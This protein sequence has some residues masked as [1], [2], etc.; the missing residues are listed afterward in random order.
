MRLAKAAGT[1][2]LVVAG[3]VTAVALASLIV[4]PLDQRV[5]NARRAEFR[6]DELD[7]FWPTDLGGHAECLSYVGLGPHA[8]D[9]ARLTHLQRDRTAAELRSQTD[10]AATAR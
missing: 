3:F 1:R 10:S 5:V 6:R 8:S 4:N 2:G 9:A 7:W